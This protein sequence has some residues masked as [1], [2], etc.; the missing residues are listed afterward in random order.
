MAHFEGAEGFGGRTDDKFRG[1]VCF[2]PVADKLANGGV[3]HGVVADACPADVGNLIGIRALVQTVTEV[4]DKLRGHRVIS[5][6][7]GVAPEGYPDK[8]AR[9]PVRPHPVKRLVLPLHQDVPDAVEIVGGY[10][11]IPD[12]GV[13]HGAHGAPGVAGHI[14]D[15]RRL[16][17][18]AGPP[19]H[20][21]GHFEKAQQFFGAA[22]AGQL[23]EVHGVERDLAGFHGFKKPLPRI[24]AQ[25][26]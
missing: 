21:C 3:G 8:Y 2:V 10:A 20:L 7:H 23:V 6:G 19:A 13:R 5:V 16:D 11:E 9:T 22:E 25:P 18:N 17:G 26:P 4:L 1:D 14:A 24:L 15:H 12:A